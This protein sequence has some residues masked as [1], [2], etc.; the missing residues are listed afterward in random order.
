MNKSKFKDVDYKKVLNVWNMFNCKSVLDDH[1]LN[2]TANV[3]L[4][5][6]M[7]QNFKNVCYKIFELDISYYYTS[8]GL[9]WDDFLK[10]TDAYY[11]KY[12]KH[13]DTELLSDIDMYL[14]VESS[15]RGGLLQISKRYSKANNK[16]MPDY[17]KS[18]KDS[19]IKQSIH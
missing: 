18:L 3:L 17:D 9:S 16:Y 5:T 2:L 19:S 6:D 13:F 11:M 12:N 4:L 1:N 8:A 7:W 14:F 10:Y 15:I